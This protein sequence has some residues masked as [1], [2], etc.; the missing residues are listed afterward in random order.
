MRGEGKAT[1]FKP[2]N[3]QVKVIE[4]ESHSNGGSQNT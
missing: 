3:I 2:C 1:S 4:N